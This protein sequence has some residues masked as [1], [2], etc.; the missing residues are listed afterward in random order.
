[1]D[2]FD[3][4]PFGT[5]HIDG[6]N[7]GVSKW[8]DQQ[9][10]FAKVM[11]ADLAKQHAQWGEHFQSGQDLHADNRSAGINHVAAG[12]QS[13]GGL[14]DYEKSRMHVNAITTISHLVTIVEAERLTLLYKREK[15]IKAVRT[16]RKVAWLA[17]PASIFLY[18]RLGFFPFNV[19]ILSGLIFLVFLI[20]KTSSYISKSISPREKQ[21]N[22]IAGCM[23]KAFKSSYDVRKFGKEKCHAG[24][25][26]R[27][28]LGKFYVP[29]GVKGISTNFLFN[30]NKN[31]KIKSGQVMP[32][33]VYRFLPVASPNGAI[34]IQ[35]DQSLIQTAVPY[36]EPVSLDELEY[37]ANQPT[38]AHLQ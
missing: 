21:L 15:E 34:F 17:L 36:A 32:Y 22:V 1:M 20:F 3:N 29:Q 26:Y 25:R 10:A 31:I 16:W 7:A 37:L 18:G 4:L 24:N 27:F 14:S 2:D 6:F 38:P 35:L 30:L 9:T 19:L 33:F 5:T 11:T 23:I 13:I 28:L 8:D 12:G